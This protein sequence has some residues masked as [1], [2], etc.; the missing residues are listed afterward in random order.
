MD[1]IKQTIVTVIVA[2]VVGSAGI[3]AAGAVTAGSTTSTATPTSTPQA[4]EHRHVHVR[5]LARAVAIAARTLGMSRKELVAEL[6]SGKSIAQVASER[7]VDSK[8][9][10]DAL[11]KAATTRIESATRA[12]EITAAQAT[13]LEQ[14]VPARAQK[15]VDATHSARDRERGARAGKPLRLVAQTIG[16]DHAQLLSDLRAGKTIADIARSHNVDRKT[17]VH[18][19]V[20]A[21]T[22]R[23][24]AAERAGRIDAARANKLQQNLSRRVDKLVNNWHLRRARSSSSAT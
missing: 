14:K 20:K 10:V 16:I 6:R 15:F 3:A 18:A 24:E 11:V 19:L 5:P 9:V 8:A 17:V 12:G 1:N 23:I 22:T 13:T 2:A 7:R 21:A 4:T